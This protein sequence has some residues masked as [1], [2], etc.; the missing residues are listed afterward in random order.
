MKYDI[1]CD[2]CLDSLI[3]AVNEKL[4]K[5]WRCQGG[6]AT[7]THPPRYTVFYQALVKEEKKNKNI[8]NDVINKLK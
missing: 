6:I 1:I 5:D 2:T 3:K 4:K 8:T 7:M